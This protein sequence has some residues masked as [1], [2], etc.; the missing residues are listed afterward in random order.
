MNIDAEDLLRRGMERCTEEVPV[1][2]GLAHRAARARRR[3]MAIRAVAG[4]A[5]LRSPRPP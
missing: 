1:P 2:L 3:R 4:Q 5:R